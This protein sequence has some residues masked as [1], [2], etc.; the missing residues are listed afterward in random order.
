MPLRR[1]TRRTDRAPCPDENCL[2]ARA[3]GE[4]T[5]DLEQHLDRCPR[6]LELIAFLM[7]L[8][9]IDRGRN[10]FRSAATF[11]NSPP[12]APDPNARSSG[13]DLKNKEE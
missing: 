11:S 2:Q 3:R 13:N 12:L 9:R 1:T 5:S 4:A 8:Q 7:K 6:C 10:T